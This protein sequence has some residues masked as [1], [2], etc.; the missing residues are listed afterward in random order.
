MKT[1]KKWG[2]KRENQTGR[3]SARKGVKRIQFNCMVDPTTKE[4]IKYLTK[5][6]KLSAGQILDEW[7]KASKAE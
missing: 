7:A 6:K 3:P 2:G 4:Q 1:N 5:Q